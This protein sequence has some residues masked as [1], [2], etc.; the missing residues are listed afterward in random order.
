M[1]ALTLMAEENDQLGRRVVCGAEPVRDMGIEFGRLARDEDEILVSENESDPSV[2][3]VQ[4]FVPLVRRGAGCVTEP[5]RRD[6]EF[7]SLHAPGA[8][9]ERQPGHPVPSNRL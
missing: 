3:Y 7:V 2:E 8:T 6:D 4:P 5:C 1:C 9:C